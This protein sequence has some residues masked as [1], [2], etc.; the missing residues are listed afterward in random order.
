MFNLKRLFLFACTLLCVASFTTAPF[1]FAHVGAQTTGSKSVKRKS[2]AAAAMTATLTD[3]F[4]D[5]DGN[6]RAQAGEEIT[7][8]A[9][10]VNDGT[11]DATNVNFEAPLDP[12]ATLVP[13]SVHVENNSN[14]YAVRCTFDTT[15]PFADCT[16]IGTPDPVTSGYN[17]I[18][19]EQYSNLVIQ[20]ANT[21]YNPGT[22]IFQFD[23]TVQNLTSNSFGSINGVDL[24]PA[25]VKLFVQ[26]TDVQGG[27]GSINIANQ[28]GNSFFTRPDQPYFQYNQMLA[29]DEVSAAK[30]L[31]LIVP[32]TVTS[33]TV[34]FLVST[35]VQA[36][37]VIN[38]I[39]A[40]PKNPI[41]DASGE[42]FELYNAGWFPVDLKDFL[43]NDYAT[44][45]S[46]TGCIGSDGNDCP[47]N[48]HSVA[49][50]IV[51]PPGGYVTLG[52]T[53]NTTNNGG[54]PIDYAYGASLALANS[55]DGVRVQHPNPLTPNDPSTALTIDQ[56]IYNSAA[57]SA[58]DGVSRELKNP[59][60]DNANIDGSNWADALVTAVYGPGGRGTPKAQNATY[61]PYAGN[62]NEETE[63]KLADYKTGASKADI[64]GGVTVSASVGTIGGAGGFATVT[65][66]VTVADPIPAGAT[67]LS[68]QGTVTGD[69]F[70]SL[71]TNDPA[72]DS[73]N[74]ATVTPVGFAPTAAPVTVSGR[75]VTQ[76]GR[77]IRNVLVTM[78]DA[79][80][81]ERTALT[82]S[83]G[84]YR[85]GDVTAGETVVIRVKAR[86]FSFTQSSLVRST[87]DQISDADFI[88]VQ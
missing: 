48:S 60:L 6:G 45:N 43:I 8:T 13:G 66:R 54:V 72:T 61:T 35:T 82:T 80:G 44:S 3:S 39:L 24:D 37:L 15:N 49:S 62:L 70:A 14:Y 19:G 69:N 74:D 71:V 31:Q 28:D 52:N 11:T 36:N 23:T 83:F 79:N 2:L 50:N 26:E 40:N 77:G 20:T 88:S 78:T 59:A 32:N 47:R 9:T 86:R 76:S 38:E 10:I 27:T 4:A 67:Q 29:K 34:D 46:T 42:W 7:Y 64:A 22:E 55:L 16:S 21:V 1:N 63:K 33:F 30:T 53:T 58:Q 5:T 51:V 68:S 84:Y 25:G 57:I 81:N 56:A 85:F 87:N 75:V 12:N 41:T 65:Y 17:K 18:L 73:A